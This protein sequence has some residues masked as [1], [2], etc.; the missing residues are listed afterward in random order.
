[1]KKTFSSF[2]YPLRQSERHRSPVY[3]RDWL[4][5]KLQQVNWAR[6]GWI[7]IF[8]LVLSVILDAALFWA[9]GRPENAGVIRPVLALMIPVFSLLSVSVYGQKQFGMIAILVFL[10]LLY[11]VA[12]Y[13]FIGFFDQIFSSDF[14]AQITEPRA[15]QLLVGTAVGLFLY[16]L[17][18]SFRFWKDYSDFKQVTI[19]LL[20]LNLAA[21]IIFGYQIGWEAFSGLGG[22]AVLASVLILATEGLKRLHRWL[23]A[24]L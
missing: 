11:V 6:L 16:S 7:I 3:Y 24:R 15:I 8:S 4:K 2:H 22:A 9:Q 13:F 5:F 21:F 1:M 17:S 19:A 20:G 14:L 18:Y 23:K 12:A 10:Q